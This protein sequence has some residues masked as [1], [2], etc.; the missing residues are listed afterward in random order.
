[1]PSIEFIHLES[2]LRCILCINTEN[3][4]DI[5]R[6]LGLYEKKDSRFRILAVAFRVWGNVIKK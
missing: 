1:M 2:N 6:L 4:L 3:A 5:S